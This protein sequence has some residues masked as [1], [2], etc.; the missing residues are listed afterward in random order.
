MVFV[1]RRLF[2]I[3]SRA[4]QLVKGGEPA[5][6][7]FR[8]AKTFVAACLVLYARSGLVATSS[9]QGGRMNKVH[10]G[11][12]IAGIFVLGFLLA[13]V[14]CDPRGRVQSFLLACCTGHCSWGPS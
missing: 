8:A 3:S 6:R 10:M 1:L 11:L 7:R 12:G 4:S 2:M 5:T 9:S 14:R 13:F